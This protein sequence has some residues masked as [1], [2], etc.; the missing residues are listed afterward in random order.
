[1]IRQTLLTAAAVMMLSLP[2]AVQAEELGVLRDR[3]VAAM[4]ARNEANAAGDYK[5]ACQ[6]SHTGVRETELFM[7]EFK[8]SIDEAEAS[9]TVEDALLKDSHD[10]Y[11]LLAEAQVK[12][13][14]LDAE[15]CAK[16][17]MAPAP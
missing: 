14:Q 11:D 3:A 10:T 1:M 2:Q 9:G 16:A 6:H 8:K 7:A 13:R 17:G 4:K 15:V 12:N 5:A